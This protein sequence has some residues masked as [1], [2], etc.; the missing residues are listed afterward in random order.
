MYFTSLDRRLEG[1]NRRTSAMRPRTIGTDETRTEGKRGEP[2]EH[3]ET[4]GRK[5]TAVVGFSAENHGRCQGRREPFRG[6]V[7]GRRPDE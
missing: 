5:R 2:D 3:N 4:G 6:P 7:G 1:E